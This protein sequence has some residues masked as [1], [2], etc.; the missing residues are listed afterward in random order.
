MPTL[1]HHLFAPSNRGA[2]T[3]RLDVTLAMAAMS[4]GLLSGSSEGLLLS[5]AAANLLTTL[6]WIGA[7]WAP[8]SG[9]P[10]MSSLLP[11]LAAMWLG[12]LFASLMR[13]LAASSESLSWA[14]RSGV[15]AEFATVGVACVWL[16]G[17]WAWLQA[18][19]AA[20][21]QISRLP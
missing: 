14:C 16:V 7:A 5:A 21:R 6:R 13:Q 9:V 20:S 3:L 8:E 17:G 1:L 11:A 10:L 12:V 18:A 4:L 19:Q 2:A 15:P